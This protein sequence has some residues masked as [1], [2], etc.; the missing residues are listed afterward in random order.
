ML[1]N[2]GKLFECNLT[3]GN[4]HPYILQVYDDKNDIES[5]VLDRLSELQWF[6]DHTKNQKTKEYIGI[7]YKS[8]T[9]YNEFGATDNTY[10]VKDDELKQFVIALNDEVN[11]E[12]CRVRT[13]NV[14]YGG[15]NNDI[16]FRISSVGFN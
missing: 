3:Y 7:I 6:Y 15:N 5:L 4:Y 10:I 8:L 2:D 12:F 9:G 11:N 16:Y 1:R 14:K 13:S